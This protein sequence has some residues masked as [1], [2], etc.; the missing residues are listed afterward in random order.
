ML[1]KVVSLLVILLSSCFGQT[2]LLLEQYATTE[3]SDNNRTLPTSD[4]WFQQG[5]RGKVGMFMWAQVSPTYRQTYSG[6]SYQ[7]TNWLQ[8]GV[9][10]GV[11]EADSLARLGSFLYLSKGSDSLFGIYENGGSGRWHLAVY[12]HKVGKSRFGV[13]FHNQAFVGSGP[14]AEVNFGP[15]KFWVATLLEKSGHNFI[16][17]VRYVY[18]K[19]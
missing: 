9:G 8:A 19:E 2:F 16:Y 1:F 13:G 15:V 18:F 10:G 14:R 6:L 3:K 17:G 7:F 4:I 11:E 12:N 5:L